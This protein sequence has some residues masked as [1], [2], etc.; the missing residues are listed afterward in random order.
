[1]TRTETRKRADHRRLSPARGLASV[2]SREWL[3]TALSTNLQ[4]LAR[5]LPSK[6]LRFYDTLQK[7]APLNGSQLILHAK[8]P[9]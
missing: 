2:G 5:P 4:E 3:V 1:L 7:S 9:E 6:T 8:H